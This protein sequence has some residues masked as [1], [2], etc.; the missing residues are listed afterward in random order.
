MPMTRLRADLMIG[1][2][3]QFFTTDAVRAWEVA[4]EAVKAANAVETFR[5]MMPFSSFPSWPTVV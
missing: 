5:A 3:N 1:I 4:A 2:A